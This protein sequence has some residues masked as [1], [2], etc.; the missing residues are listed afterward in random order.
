[1]HGEG[2][3]RREFSLMHEDSTGE[4]TI[5]CS[6]CRDELQAEELGVP[7]DDVDRAQRITWHKGQC[8]E[9]AQKARDRF[10]EQWNREPA[11]AVEH[12]GGEVMETDEELGLWMSVDN[13]VKRDRYEEGFGKPATHWNIV[14]AYDHVANRVKERMLRNQL[15]D[16]ERAAAAEFVKAGREV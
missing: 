15:G 14:Q 3:E 10:M 11:Y 16:R 12:Y 2:E 1:L 13:E 7:A 4:Y 9:Q 6:R 8:E 5:Y